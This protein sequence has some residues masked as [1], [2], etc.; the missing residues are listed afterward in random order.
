MHPQIVL[1]RW[2]T[3]GAL[4]Y[5]V[6]PGSAATITIWDS[7]AGSILGANWKLLIWNGIASAD[8]GSSGLSFEESFDDGTNW[9]VIVAYTNSASTVY[10]RFVEVAAPRIRVRYTNS[11]AVLTVW[12]GCLIGD[13]RER[14]N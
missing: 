6:A 9:D 7:G 5:I 8:S 3:G 13:E 4:P 11:A 2:I 12:R 1:A 14:A 10:Q